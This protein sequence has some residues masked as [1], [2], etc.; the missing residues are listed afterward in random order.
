[1]KFNWGTGILVAFIAFISFIMF[2]VITMSTN[3][4][5]DHD[6]V[7]ENYYGKELE[8]QE[9]IN[10]LKHSQSLKKDIIWKRTTEG[11]MITFP[12]DFDSDDISGTVFFY[13]PSNKLLDF[14]IPLL[15][16]EHSMLIPNER[17]LDGRWNLTVTWK[18]KGISYLYKKEIVYQ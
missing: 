16:S 1:M 4:T 3:K 13:R 11:M 15:V 8:F 5:Y 14:E 12:D 18:A 17:L 9:D 6:L 7:T 2:F 10:Q